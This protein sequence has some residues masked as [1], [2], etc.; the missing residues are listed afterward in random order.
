MTCKKC[1]SDQNVKNGNRHGKQSFLCKCCGHQFT[2]DN[3][4]AYLE[5]LAAFAYYKAGMSYRK[6][7]ELLRYSHV[8]IQNWVRELSENT[9]EKLA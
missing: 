2:N 4:A 9:A 7:G 5:K 6:I 1:D 8:T 3:A